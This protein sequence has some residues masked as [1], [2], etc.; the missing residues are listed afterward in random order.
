MMGE[1]ERKREWEG[2][3]K[4]RRIVENVEEKKW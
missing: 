2:A 4:G 1:V 3:N